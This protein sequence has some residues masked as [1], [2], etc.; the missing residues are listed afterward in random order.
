MNY[1]YNSFLS[2]FILF[3]FRGD[4]LSLK[5]EFVPNKLTLYGLLNFT[6]IWSLQNYVPPSLY[7]CSSYQSTRNAEYFAV[8]VNKIYPQKLIS[9]VTSTDKG[10]LYGKFQVGAEV[11]FL[12]NWCKKGEWMWHL[13]IRGLCWCSSVKVLIVSDN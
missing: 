3:I 12:W 6:A 5:I 1:L 2:L 13:M 8:L 9:F 4:N 10:V 7:V 11:S